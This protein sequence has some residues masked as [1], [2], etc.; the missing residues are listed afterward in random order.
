MSEEFDPFTSN[1]EDFQFDQARDMLENGL[2]ELLEYG[3]NLL[4]Q[5]KLE[6]LNKFITDK[7]RGLDRE[8]DIREM[9]PYSL[10]D[11]KEEISNN[12]EGLKTSWPAVDK[13]IRIPQEAITIVAGQPSHGKTSVL[14]NLFIN[15]VKQYPKK[16]FLFYSYEENSKHLALKIIMNL[17]EHC[18]DEINNFAFFEKMMK[19]KNSDRPAIDDAV[20]QLESLTES[21]R[22]WLLDHGPDLDD[23]HKELEFLS[24]SGD[25][26]GVFIDY[27]QKMKLKKCDLDRQ[28][29]LQIVSNELLRMAKSFKIPIIL[30]AQLEKSKAGEAVKLDQL[31]DAGDIEQDANLI[32]GLYN[33]SMIKAGQGVKV[34]DRLVDLTLSI[35]KNRNGAVNQDIVLRFD[36][37]VL[38]IRDFSTK[39]IMSAMTQKIQRL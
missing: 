18:E 27:V 25:I 24:K 4:K 10:V 19:N 12:A 14:L 23:L 1:Q 3:S 9:R 34:N 13:L 6:E 39:N 37:P 30:G 29:E 2:Q 5:N 21:K 38:K 33:K 31:R 35:L 11:L 36:R 32:L 26:G 22:L 7:T 8:K 20:K 15:S 17:S 16:Q 28:R